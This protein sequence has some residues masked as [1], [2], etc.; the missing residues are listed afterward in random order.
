MAV[1]VAALEKE[2]MIMVLAHPVREIEAVQEIQ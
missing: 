2:L 1:Q